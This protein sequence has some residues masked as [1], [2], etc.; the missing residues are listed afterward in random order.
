MNSYF[1]QIV[2]QLD[3]E[4]ANVICLLAC[5]RLE[6]HC[7]A[8]KVRLLSLPWLT[9]VCSW[10]NIYAVQPWFKLVQS[11]YSPGSTR[12]PWSGTFSL[13]LLSLVSI[14]VKH[15]AS[16]TFL[17]L[18]MPRILEPHRTRGGSG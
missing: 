3:N 2:P 1:L 9:S 7:Y 4:S 8:K 12:Y 17:A 18:R 11:W 6:T 5:V 10:L 15:K 13:F 14:G 16:N